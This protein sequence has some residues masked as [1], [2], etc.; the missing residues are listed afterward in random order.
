M[1][2]RVQNL[3]PLSDAVS[4]VSTALAA[5]TV[6][7]AAG[8]AVLSGAVTA[9]DTHANLVSAA[10]VVASALATTADTHANAAS[11]AAATVSANVT[12]LGSDVGRLSLNTSAILTRLDVVSGVA[13]A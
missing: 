9:A 13:A 11:A 2:N 6:A 5:E 8:D 7:R 10:V 3:G 1:I 12:S 4:V